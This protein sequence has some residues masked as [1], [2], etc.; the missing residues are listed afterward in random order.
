MAK[1]SSI[2]R[3]TLLGSKGKRFASLDARR[4][5]GRK[6]LRIELLEARQLLAF[7]VLGNSFG[8][9][10]EG[11]FCW[12]DTGSVV[13]SSNETIP[14]DSAPEFGPLK[15]LSIPDEVGVMPLEPPELM[16]WNRQFWESVNR[17]GDSPSGIGDFSQGMFEPSGSDG[18][19]GA[20]SGASFQ[21]FVLADTFKLHSRPTSTKTLFLDFDGFEARG[22]PWNQSYNRPAIVSPPYDPARDGPAFA[23]AELLQIQQIWHRVAEHF[24]PFDVNITT[25]EPVETD[26]VRSGSG[27]ERWGL[28]V[29]QTV[30]NFASCGCGGFAYIDSF[31]W[32][33]HSAGATDTPAYSFNVSPPAASITISHE[34]GHALGLSHDGAGSQAYYPGHGTGETRWGT[35]MGAAFSANVQHW[36]RGE[37]TGANNTGASANYNRGPDDLVVITTINGFGYRV[38]EAGDTASTAAEMER[39]SKNA[40]DPTLM[41]VSFFGVI[42][43]SND[44]DMVRFQTGSGV[45]DLTVDSYAG[46]AWVSDDAGGFNPKIQSTNFST[47]WSANL[48]SSLDILARLYKSD[49]TLVAESNPTG[50]SASFLGLTLEAGTYYLSMQGTGFGNPLGNPPTGYTSYGSLGQYFVRGTIVDTSNPK[51]IGVASDIEFATSDN[52]VI[53]VTYTDNVGINLETLGTGDI[54][55]TGPNDYDEIATFLGIIEDADLRSVVV[56]YSVPAPDGSWSDAANGD[57]SIVIGANEV[58]NLDGEFVETGIIGGFVVDIAPTLGPDAFGYVAYAKRYEFNDISQTGALILAGQDDNAE[59]IT[60]ANGFL[61]NFYG[62]SYETLFVS[63]NGLLTFGSANN[64]FENTD[65]TNSPDTPAIAVLWDDLLPEISTGV[66]WQLFGSGD[67]QYLIIQWET[68]YFGG[69]GRVSFQVILREHENTIQTNYRDLLGGHTQRDQGMSATVGIKSIGSQGDDRLLVS[70][71]GSGRRYAETGRSLFL[72][73]INRPMVD[74]LL[75]AQSYTE[76]S[77]AGTLVGVLSTIDPDFDDTFTYALVDGDGSVNNSHFE[78]IGNQLH[79]L[80]VFDFEQNPTQSVRV[81]TTDSAGNWL[82]RAFVIQIIDLPELDSIT[83]ANGQTQRSRVD[84]LRVV[85]DGQTTWDENAFIVTRRGSGELISVAVTSSV[86]SQGQT[87]AELRFTGP[88]T[89]ANGALI[90]G[91][92]LLAIDGSKIF[93]N[94]QTLDSNQDGIGGDTVNFGNQAT[95]RF[96]ALLGDSNGSRNV[97]MIDFILFRS[98]FGTTSSSSN[99]NRSLDFDDNGVIDMVDFIQFRSR[100]GSQLNF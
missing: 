99:Y 56:Q 24:A 53:N 90:D 18:S 58:A 79:S 14:H 59:S 3:R 68:G 93:R 4:S 9:D 17:D 67:E 46:K 66:Y 100:F 7:G 81:R 2:E 34:A 13:A 76:N 42:T 80:K 65:L 10:I 11:E 95:D 33:Y 47:N 40:N 73:R 85:F 83:V 98:A 20:S 5:A 51:A 52:V 64:S 72:E 70:V 35:I 77:P 61:F 94:G 16:E 22:T 32:G 28:R 78:I 57:Y 19:A 26:L 23:N 63:S 92:Y 25:Q 82:E 71:D 97:D 39:H 50:L 84:N 55:V 36:S 96:F 30:D 86:N 31:N 62:V 1:S 87:V 89:R 37:Y 48:G 29:V 88:F 38:D 15:L 12:S 45:V 6:R 49:G 8:I 75:S 91:N 74:I 44:V 43:T 41:D 69:D 21:P 60:P 54:R 27:D